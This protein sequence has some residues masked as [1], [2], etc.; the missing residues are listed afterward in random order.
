MVLEQGPVGIAVMVGQVWIWKVFRP[1]V[2]FVRCDLA[3]SRSRSGRCDDY[4][5]LLLSAMFRDIHRGIMGWREEDDKSRNEFSYG[6]CHSVFVAGGFGHGYM[7]DTGVHWAYSTFDRAHVTIT[8]RTP[9]NAEP[10]TLPHHD[11]TPTS[12]RVS[13]L[14]QHRPTVPQTFWTYR[15]HRAI[16]RCKPRR[17]T[18]QK[19]QRVVNCEND[20]RSD[21]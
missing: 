16:S 1:F 2:V 12:P 11:T 15:A 8:W 19:S 10:T 5:V 14:T 4:T 20:V 9:R 13:H 3:F 7:G 18:G 6:G 17:A 21:N